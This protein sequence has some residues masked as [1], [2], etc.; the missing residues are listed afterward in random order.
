MDSARPTHTK[1]DTETK[2]VA[3]CI[4]FVVDASYMGWLYAASHTRHV[5]VC[6]TVFELVAYSG[7]CM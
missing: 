4:I 2:N 5:A 6:M 1:S 3:E 7:S